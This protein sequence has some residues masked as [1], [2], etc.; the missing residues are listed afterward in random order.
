MSD[1]YEQRRYLSTWTANRVPHIFTDVLVIG[2]G[3]AGMRAAI[4]AARF[5]DALVVTKGGVLQSNTAHAQGGIAVVLAEQDSYQQHMADTLQV[6]CGLG[7]NAAIETLVKQGP[8]EV[9]R[10]IE[11][12]ARFDLEADG[13]L[14][15]GRE[16]GHGLSRILHAA[17]DATGR[18][19]ADVL[20]RRVL[21]TPRLR[22]FEQCFTIDL[23]TLEGACCGAVTFH[24]KYGHQLIWA[25]QTILASG[26]AGRLY[27]ETT[28]PDVATA[29]G[30]GMAYRAGAVLRDLE[31]IQF[32]PTTLYLAGATRA[33]ISEAL[34]GEGAHL[35]DRT[36]RR[37]MPDYHEDAE[38]A[39]RDVVSRAILREMARANAPSVYLDVRHID[40]DRFAKRFPSI[41]NLCRQFDIDVGDDLIPVRPSAHYT[42]GG[43]L[44]D[45]DAR[46]TIPGLLACGEAAS[47]GVHGA[48][49]LASNSLLEGLVFGAIAG[50]TAGRAL[51]G[52]SANGHP[53]RVNSVETPAE[54]AELD[55]EDIRNSLRA[56]MTRNIGIE[57]E[58]A[59]L[60]EALGSIDFWGRYVMDKTFDDRYGWESQN[61]LTVARL[62][63][64]SA[65]HRRESRG[66]HFRDDYPELDDDR[67]RVHVTVQRTSEG[68]AIGT[69][70]VSG[71]A[72]SAR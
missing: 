23:L 66:V 29:D 35:V 53:S 67:W 10:L 42:I 5:G 37:F 62:I 13:E 41:F 3:I 36:G 49:R 71:P 70:P 25:K 15:R 40:R 61:M 47:T 11:W 32:H 1:L 44:V 21:D 33:L 72:G 18:E 27:R 50:C 24:P 38:L 55:L 9:R 65:R 54:R 52:W 60:T 45:L 8:A 28:N 69:Q 48:N 68:T 58:D 19:L 7:D 46:S 30:L 17:G 6:A 57:R 4:E 16:G 64:Q 2:S 14:S 34:R 12:G 20:V 31:M 43:L 59:R 22:V 26:G 56:L 39:P 63:A 51:A